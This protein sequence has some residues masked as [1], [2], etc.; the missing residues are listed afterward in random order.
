[1]L[2]VE[3]YVGPRYTEL[4]RSGW[5]HAGRWLS[6]LPERLRRARDGRSLV[7]RPP[8]HDRWSIQRNS[9]FEAIRSDQI[10]PILRRWFEFEEYRELGGGL[11]MPL[12][13]PIIHNFDPDDAE[14]NEWLRRMI[15]DDLRLTRNGEIPNAFVFFTARP[16]PVL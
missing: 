9:P 14:A 16:A 4:P 15:D 2:V 3:D 5:R 12:L 8:V 6:R 7:S 10:V 1:M 13:G 11:L